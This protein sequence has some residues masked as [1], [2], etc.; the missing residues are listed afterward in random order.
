MCKP[1]L[2]ALMAYELVYYAYTSNIRKGLEV[3]GIE[4]NKGMSNRF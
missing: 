1:S 2:E 4:K 3:V